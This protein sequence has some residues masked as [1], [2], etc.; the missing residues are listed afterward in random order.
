MDMSRAVIVRVDH[1]PQAIESQNGRHE[2]PYQNP[3]A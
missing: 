2:L 1:H 3:S